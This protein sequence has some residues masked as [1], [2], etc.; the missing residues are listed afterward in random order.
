MKSLLNFKDLLK[1][2]FQVGR[3]NLPLRRRLLRLLVW[4]VPCPEAQLLLLDWAWTVRASPRPVA[5]RPRTG[6]SSQNSC[7]N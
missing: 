1:S 7:T 3:G 2:H 4:F 5:C 6:K